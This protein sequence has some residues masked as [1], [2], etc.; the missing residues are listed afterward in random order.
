MSCHLTCM[1]YWRSN[2]CSKVFYEVETIDLGA[3]ISFVVD[4]RLESRGI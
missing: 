4:A 1:P 3:S 2:K